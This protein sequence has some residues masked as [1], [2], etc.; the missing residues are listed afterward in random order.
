MQH[1]ILRSLLP[2]IS[3]CIAEAL[4]LPKTEWPESHRRHVPAQVGLIAQFVAT[5]LSSICRAGKIAPSL[6]GTVQDVRDLVAYRLQLVPNGDD[7]LPALARGWRAE[8]VGKQIED[9]LTG[10]LS[11]RITDPLSDEPLSFDPVD[12]G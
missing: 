12:G 11:I 2:E 9:L 1:G 5:A 4:R 6:V 3:T 8:V 10:K 7:S